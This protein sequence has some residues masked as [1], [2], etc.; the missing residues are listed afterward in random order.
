V[1]RSCLPSLTPGS[2]WF[3]PSC[4]TARQGLAQ[5]STPLRSPPHASVSWAATT[6]ATCCWCT[7][8]GGWEGQR[9]GTQAHAHAHAH[10]PVPLQECHLRQAPDNH[11]SQQTGID[12][13]TEHPPP[14]H[15]THS[16]IYTSTSAPSS[17]PAIAASCIQLHPAQTT[18]GLRTHIPSPTISN[19]TPPP[20][21]CLFPQ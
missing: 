13:D 12:T 20:I 1:W 3:L 19:P 9:G 10:R 16:H 5:G 2:R 17:I 7:T 15:S 4:P 21:S 18:Q 14:F 6:T 11:K 8:T